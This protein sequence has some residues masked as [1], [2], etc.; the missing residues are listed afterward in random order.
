MRDGRLLL[1]NIGLNVLWAPL[2]VATAAIDAYPPAVIAAT[3]VFF[4]PAILISASVQTETR[5]EAWQ[6]RLDRSPQLRFLITSAQVLALPLTI[7][8]ILL[9]NPSLALLIQDDRAWVLG[10][11]V[12]GGSSTLF[13]PAIQKVFS[14]QPEKESVRA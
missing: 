12:G 3:V 7:L 10:G 1:V 14:A 9:M 13:G 2:L 6:L 8:L 11:V 5:S 4:W